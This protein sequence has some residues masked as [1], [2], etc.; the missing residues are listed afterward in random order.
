MQRH[1]L[2]LCPL[3]QARPHSALPGM[4]Y[5][6]QEIG[7]ILDVLML[8]A[9]LSLPYRIAPP[10]SLCPTLLQGIQDYLAHKKPPPPRTLP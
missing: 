4:L 10:L 2:P 6:Y 8:L 9:P 1:C 5:L 3:W 7:F